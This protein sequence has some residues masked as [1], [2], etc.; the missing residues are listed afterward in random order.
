M[1]SAKMT[2]DQHVTALQTNQPSGRVW[3][4]KLRPGSNFFNLLLGLAPTFR[5]MDAAIQTF[6]AET[7]PP[8]TTRF[9]SEWEKALGLP[10]D[11]LPIASDVATRQRNILIKLV[12]L[13]GLATDQDFVN[14]GALFGLVIEV[15]SGIEH[16]APGDGGYGTKLPEIVVPTHVADEAEARFTMVI[17]ETFPEAITF[18]WE[19]PLLFSTTGQL[20]LRCIIEK[21][22]PANVNVLF[23]E[24]P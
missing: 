11:C 23:L 4:P 10:D 1:S 5:E 14:L 20:E 16:L 18:P 8:T 22:A 6:V 3:L 12:L 15:N 7:F 9:L 19:F 17:V 2:V 21:L 24:A 13:S